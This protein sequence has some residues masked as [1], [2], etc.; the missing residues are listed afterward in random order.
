[1]YNPETEYET[2]IMRLKKIC[3][4]KKMTSYALANAAGISTSTLSYMLSGKTKPQI[5]TVLMLCNALEIS[6]VDLF[7]DESRSQDAQLK[8]KRTPLSEE[9]VIQRYRQF[10]D[11]KKEM[12]EIYLNMLEQY[13]DGM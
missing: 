7:T 8:K 2:M 1:M 6:I 4:K 9:S 10:S 12:L 11:R 13:E 5:H 3:E